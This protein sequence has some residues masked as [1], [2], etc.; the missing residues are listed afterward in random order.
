ML[1]SDNSINSI[2]K[3]SGTWLTSTRC[4]WY[5]SCKLRLRFSKSLNLSWYPSISESRTNVY[6]FTLHDLPVTFA[7]W[8]KCSAEIRGC[9]RTDFLQVSFFR[10]AWIFC[11]ISYIDFVSP[12]RET[13]SW[14]CFDITSHKKAAFLKKVC[15]DKLQDI[16]LSSKKLTICF[17][18]DKTFSSTCPCDNQRTFEWYGRS[19]LNV[20]SSYWSVWRNCRCLL[21]FARM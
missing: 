16:S 19:T 8:G 18:K 21:A 20:S 14:F 5:A 2:W 7:S 1:S 11:H 10:N 3:R 15:S 6:S 12:C 9:L 17:C 13:L 4:G